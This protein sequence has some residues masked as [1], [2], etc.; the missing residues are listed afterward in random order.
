MSDGLLLYRNNSS[1]LQVK[2][3]NAD[4]GQWINNA[5]VSLAYLKHQDDSAVLPQTFPT[6]LVYVTGSNGEYRCTLE[7]GLI[8]TEYEVLKS[9][10][11]FDA[12]AGMVGQVE[13]DI[14][15]RK[16]RGT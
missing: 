10:I 14:V 4:N 16:R 9:L 8:V 2:L 15:V 6:P 13:P 5:T 7:D 11:E 12:G 1:R 3:K